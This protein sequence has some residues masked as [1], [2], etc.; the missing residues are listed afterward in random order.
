MRDPTAMAG[1]VKDGTT[2]HHGSSTTMDA[3]WELHDATMG[4][5]PPWMQAGSSAT[6]PWELHRGQARAIDE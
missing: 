4:A 5:P 2:R 1:S 6:P 3:K